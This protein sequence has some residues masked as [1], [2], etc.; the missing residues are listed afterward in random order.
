MSAAPHVNPRPPGS[1]RGL[2]R[3]YP[4]PSLGGPVPVA[5]CPLLDATGP[6]QGGSRFNPTAKSRSMH[7]HTSP[8][9][10]S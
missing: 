3:L 10:G 5:E 6:C 4:E 1:V 8:V 9:D 2:P 7:V